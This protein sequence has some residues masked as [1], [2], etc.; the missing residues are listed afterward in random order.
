ME[1]VIKLHIL[2]QIHQNVI[3]NGGYY[4]EKKLIHLE[5]SII[6]RKNNKI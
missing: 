1:L 4:I 5:H 2:E 3:A 6:K